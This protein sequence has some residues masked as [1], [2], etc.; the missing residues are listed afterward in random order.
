MSQ[1]PVSAVRALRTPKNPLDRATAALGP[2][3]AEPPAP[4]RPA[5]EE[6]QE[7]NV[8]GPRKLIR[9]TLPEGVAR[10]RRFSRRDE[11]VLQWISGAATSHAAHESSH[12]EAF[13]FQKQMQSQTP[14]VFVL[15]DGDTIEGCI[16]WYD[17]NAIKVRCTTARTSGARSADVP[18]RALI[19]KASIKYLYKAGENQGLL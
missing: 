18:T 3:A 15:E 2:V 8:V 17:R 12:A 10:D 5:A 4:A 7:L 16:E 14:M 6:P 19:Y 1:V 9:P 13:Y 11:P